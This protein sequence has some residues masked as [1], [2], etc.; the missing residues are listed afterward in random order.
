[1][2]PVALVDCLVGQYI[3]ENSWA[4]L[5]SIEKVPTIDH[6]IRFEVVFSLTLVFAI[7]DVSCV[8]VAVWQIYG[9]YAV[10]F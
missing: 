9:Q 1:M 7:L 5:F 8:N 2:L 10:F 3:Y 4:V 6:V